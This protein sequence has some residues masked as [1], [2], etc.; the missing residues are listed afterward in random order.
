M[1]H[2]RGCAVALGTHVASLARS[3]YSQ[4]SGP[5]SFRAQQLPA[6]RATGPGSLPTREASFLQEGSSVGRQIVKKS[7]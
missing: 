7:N 1:T 6:P 4:L 3:S 2:D 5:S